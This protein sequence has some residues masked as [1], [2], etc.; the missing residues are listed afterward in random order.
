MSSSP[1]DLVAVARALAADVLAPAAADVDLRSEVPRTHLQA[2]ADAGFYG[3]TGPRDAGGLDA[4]A[5]TTGA[6]VEE[7]A[8]GDL[9]TTFVLLQHLG[10]VRRVAASPLRDEWLTALCAGRRRSGVALQAALRP[11]PA[12]VTARREGG[13]VVLDG[14]VP[15]VTGWGLVDVLLVAARDGDD[16]VF[17]LVDAV[18]SAAV[19]A[20]RQPL[21]AVRG[22]G[23]VDLRLTGLRVPSS[24]VVA[25]APLAGLLARDPG[26]LRL[27]GSLS[28]GVAL[29][30]T[31]EIGPTALD[32]ALTDVRSRLDAAGPEDLPAARAAAAALA[33]RAAGAL[34]SSSGSRA[35]LAGSLAERTLREAAFLLVFGS[36]PAIRTALVGELT[37]R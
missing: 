36:R 10:V 19:V 7:L 1:D 26:G 9:A 20:T 5:S 35:L 12:A 30:C 29:R 18:D 8:A 15:W 13:D 17:V 6:V 14:A 28:L 16:V 4:T 34:F 37:S 3:L 11:G 32:T 23:T 21:V 25:T 31:R 27:N 2:L 22:S 24:R 33:H